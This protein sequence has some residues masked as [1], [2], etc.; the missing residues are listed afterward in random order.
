MKLSADKLAAQLAAKLLPVYLISGDEPLLVGEAADRVRAAARAAGCSERDVHFIE[1]NSGW[2]DIVHAAQALSLFTSRR[3]LEVRIPGGKPGNGAASL[4]TV[5][6]AAGDDLIVLI[7]TGRLDWEAQ[8]TEWFKAAQA[9]GAWVPVELK[10]AGSFT[11]WLATRMRQRGLQPDEQALAVLA[12]RTE[13]NL[14]A[15]QQEIDKLALQGSTSV[16]AAAV[17]ASVTGSTRFDVNQLTEAALQGDAG[18][19]QR[20]VASLRSDGTEPTLVLW[21]ILRDMRSLW[22]ALERSAAAAGGAPGRG[23]SRPTPGLDAALA[24]LR[25]TNLPELFAR[26]AARAARA[27]RINKG[28]LEGDAWDEIALL[29]GELAGRRVLPLPAA[30]RGAAARAKR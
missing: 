16:D 22:S 21:A 15:A 9:R 14:L 18:R 19:A 4:L 12:E 3:L 24:R 20:I 17:L 30:G 10:D 28:Q 6:E 26:L 2:Q 27:D 25:R 23:W 13:G 29:T 5:I 11:Q 1:R 7:V 8:K